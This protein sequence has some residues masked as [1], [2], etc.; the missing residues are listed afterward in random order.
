[1]KTLSDLVPGEW[2]VVKYVDEHCSLCRRLTDMGIIP[3]TKIQCTIKSPMGDPVAYLV[4]GTVIS[5]RKEDSTNI[6]LE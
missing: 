5:L 3:G 1:M 2:G 4:R 6:V